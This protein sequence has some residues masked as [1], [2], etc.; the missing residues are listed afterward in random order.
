MLILF[1]SGHRK[2]LG[3]RIMESEASPVMK[4]SFCS[5]RSFP[6]TMM[7]RRVR[8][9]VCDAGKRPAE[10]EWFDDQLQPDDTDLSWIWPGSA[11]LGRFWVDDALGWKS[12]HSEAQK[13]SPF[14]AD[15]LVQRSIQLSVAKSIGSLESFFG[16]VP[17]FRQSRWTIQSPFPDAFIS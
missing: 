10:R 6:S 13:T 16:A 7:A 2:F 17:D 12:V 14:R 4:L 9:S 11:H 8:E 3:L 15:Q 5:A 1:V